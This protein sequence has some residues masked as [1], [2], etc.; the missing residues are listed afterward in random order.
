MTQ[1]FP[2]IFCFRSIH[3]SYFTKFWFKLTHDSKTYLEYWFKSWLSDIKMLI[4]LTFLGFQSILLTFFGLS[5]HFVN[6]F[7]GIWLMCLY[8]NQ[9]VTQAAFQELT[10][11]SWLKWIPQVLIQIDL[12]LKVILIFFIQINSWPKHKAYHSESTHDLTLSHTH[13]GTQVLAKVLR[14]SGSQVFPIIWLK[15][16]P[17][18]HFMHIS[19]Y[20]GSAQNRP[21]I[22]FHAISGYLL[23]LLGINGAC[24]VGML[25][26]SCR[27]V[28]AI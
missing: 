14:S 5:L 17:H 8:L 7:L 9:L 24:H 12:L 3:Y 25:S 6:L 2:G 21:K 28:T 15:W 4:L 27:K 10:H 18:A 13:Y 23:T 11:N 19:Q 26:E 16:R 22:Q 1:K 20:L